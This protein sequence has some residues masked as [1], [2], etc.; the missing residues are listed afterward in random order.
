MWWDCTGG[1]YRHQPPPYNEQ[2]R[3]ADIAQAREGPR[4]GLQTLK[5]RPK[6]RTNIWELERD[7]YVCSGYF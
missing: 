2:S 3:V 5:T 6:A 4:A 7:L 1:S